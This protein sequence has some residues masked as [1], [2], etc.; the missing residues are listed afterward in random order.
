MLKLGAATADLLGMRPREIECPICDAD[1]SLAGDEKP[2]DE[3]F[4]SYC[5]APMLITG[6]KEDEI[7]FEEEY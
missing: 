4:C 1:I 5:G 6:V 3:V 7:E 2:G